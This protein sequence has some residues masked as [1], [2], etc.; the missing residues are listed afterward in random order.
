MSNSSGRFNR[1]SRIPN[2]VCLYLFPHEHCDNWLQV[3]QANGRTNGVESSQ[4]P[5]LPKPLAALKEQVRIVFN[6]EVKPFRVFQSKRNV[7]GQPGA[8]VRG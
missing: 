7:V 2:A 4:A 8:M 6:T 5:P 1:Q 3:S